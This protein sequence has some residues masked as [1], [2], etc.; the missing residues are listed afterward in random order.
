M[1]VVLITK[2]CYRLCWKWNWYLWCGDQRSDN[3]VIDRQSKKGTLASLV[4]CGDLLFKSFA[5]FY[6]VVFVCYYL[7]IW[8]GFVIDCVMLLLTGKARKRLGLLLLFF[9]K[10][11]SLIDHLFCSG[12]FW[13]DIF[14]VFLLNFFVNFFVNSHNNFHKTDYHHHKAFRCNT[15]SRAI[16]SNLHLD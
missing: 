1:V 7:Y 8:S 11:R 2:Y 10:T 6:L 9:H 12:S 15:W 13:N 16:T 4:V 14:L 3:V 5:R